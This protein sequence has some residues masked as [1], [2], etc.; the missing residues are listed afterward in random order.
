MKLKTAK[1]LWQCSFNCLNVRN[2][3]LLLWG[4][5][6]GA[7]GLGITV[8]SKNSCTAIKCWKKIVQGERDG[9]HLFTASILNRSCWPAPLLLLGQVALLVLFTYCLVWPLIIII[10]TLVNAR[11]AMRRNIEQVLY[12]N[13]VLCL[14]F[15]KFLHNLCCLT[16]IVMHNL[17][18]TKKFH[19]PEN[20]PN[21][22]PSKKIM[23]HPFRMW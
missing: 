13:Q 12:T 9:L 18:V 6:E 10:K 5:P 8:M 7:D 23:A 21:P 15:I 14:T 20:R 1:F 11:G 16:K 2:G 17:K 3:S 4:E 19:A 22:P